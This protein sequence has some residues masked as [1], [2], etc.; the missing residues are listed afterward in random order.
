MVISHSITQFIKIH[1]IINWRKYICY[2]IIMCNNKRLLPK[3]IKTSKTNLNSTNENFSS[4]KYEI[5]TKT[6]FVRQFNLFWKVSYISNR[7]SSTIGG[8]EKWT[9]YTLRHKCQIQQGKRNFLKLVDMFS[10]NTTEYN[11][12]ESVQI[13]RCHLLYKTLFGTSIKKTYELLLVRKSHTILFIIQI[14]KIRKEFWKKIDIR[15]YA[16]HL[17]FLYV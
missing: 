5:L 12:T 17:G 14:K 16:K 9:N 1:K 3:T 11:C 6:C 7:L 15:N 2:F 13:L 8:R 10:K 4:W